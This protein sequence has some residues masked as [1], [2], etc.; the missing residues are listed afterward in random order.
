MR[1]DELEKRIAAERGHLDQIEKVPVD[2]IWN[3]LEPHLPAKGKSAARPWQIGR[4]WRIILLAASLTLVVGLSLWLFLPRP[5]AEA[6]FRVATLLPELA[7]QEQAY[8]K[9]IAE[10]ESEIDLTRIDRQA[11]QDVFQELKELENARKQAKQDI[12]SHPDKEEILS[13]LMRYYERKLLILDRLEKEL[14]RN[15]IQKQRDEKLHI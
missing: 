7:P 10:R 8:L 1:T 13:I 14:D 11:F 2:R 3:K 9:K 12:A 15:K 4:H 5:Q 6:E